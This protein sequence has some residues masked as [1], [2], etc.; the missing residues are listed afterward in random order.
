MAVGTNRPAAVSG[1]VVDGVEET[2]A[3]VGLGRWTKPG[4]TAAARHHR[5]FVGGHVRGMYQAPLTVDVEIVIQPFDRT[6]SAPCKAVV[7]FPGL[8]GNVQVNRG[9]IIERSDD[10]G[11]QFAVDRTQRMRRD[12]NSAVGVAGGG[13]LQTFDDVDE[14]AG[15]VQ[16]TFLAVQRIGAAETAVTVK[17]R[18]GGKSDADRARCLQALQAHFGAVVIGTAID[19]VVQVLEFTDASVPGLEH[20]QV[21]L[22]GNVLQVLGLDALE[23]VIHDLAPCPETVGTVAGAFA[24]TGHGAL[25]RVRMHVR[26]R[27]DQQLGAFA[28]AVV[29]A[30]R[31][32]IDSAVGID[33]DVDAT[34]PAVVEQSRRRPDPGCH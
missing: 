26:Y 8:F 14:L 13:R 22:R 4:D 25:V 24:E 17:H 30:R 28:A 31:H 9:E 16:E 34:G 10:L 15:A 33:A 2:V 21:K 6:F 12:A 20:L 29:A 27:R 18:Q 19:A 5:R 1:Q 11:Q 32:R 3:E 23:V 7:D